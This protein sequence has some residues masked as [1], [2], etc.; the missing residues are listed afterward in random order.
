MQRASTKMITKFCK[1]A[2]SWHYMTGY[3]KGNKK[4]L[5]D[6]ISNYI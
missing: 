2:V 4:Y 3:R 6:Y 1:L 5:L